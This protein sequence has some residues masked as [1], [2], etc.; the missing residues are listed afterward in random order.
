M[1]KQPKSVP[2]VTEEK[3]ESS[4]EAPAEAPS[5]PV[6]FPFNRKKIEEAFETK[7][8][9][10]KPLLNKAKAYI[11]PVL[12]YMETVEARLQVADKNFQQISEFLTKMEPLIQLSQQV[13]QQQTSGGSVA[14]PVPGGAGNILGL[15]SQFAPLLGGGSNPLGD[16]LT[17]KVLDAGLD[18]MFAGTQ[19]LKAMQQKIMMEMGVKAVMDATK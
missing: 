10:M 13:Q 8:P 12:D 15:I 1:K 9:L 5:A 18:Q 19:L 14:A 11:A 7:D 6:P 3:P 17:K 4:K 2:A 16:E